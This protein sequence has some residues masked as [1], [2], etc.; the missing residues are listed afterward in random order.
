MTSQKNFESTEKIRSRVSI[1]KPVAKTTLGRMVSS[2]GPQNFLNSEILLGSWKALKCKSEIWSQQGSRTSVVPITIQYIQNKQR[3]T[4]T[5]PIKLSEFLF[6][7]GYLRVTFFRWTSES[8][9]SWFKNMRNLFVINPAIRSRELQ[10]IM[11]I[12]PGRIM[13]Q[14]FND[15]GI[16]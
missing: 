13:I 12:L 7:T 9:S 8:G 15:S 11:V 2:V 5:I 1:A 4:W 16:L 3:L 6:I 10:N 14:L